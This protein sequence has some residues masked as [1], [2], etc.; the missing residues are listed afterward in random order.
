MLKPIILLASSVILFNGSPLHA[1]DRDPISNEPVNKAA[2][3]QHPETAKDRN[4]GSSSQPYINR[5]V[6]RSLTLSPLRGNELADKRGI[7]TP[8][9]P[10]LKKTGASGAEQDYRTKTKRKLKAA[11]AEDRGIATPD[12]WHNDGK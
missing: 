4:I 5:S 9:H 7:G 1:Q 2:T 12:H 3:D 8:E 10:H 6:E 11:P